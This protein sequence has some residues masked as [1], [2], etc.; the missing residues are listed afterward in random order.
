MALIRATFA[1][2]HYFT[3]F[4]NDRPVFKVL[5]AVCTL[6]AVADAAC[7]A[8]WSFFWVGEPHFSPSPL[9][10]AEVAPRTVT[11]YGDIFVLMGM[12]WHLPAYCG[13]CVARA[14]HLRRPW[15]PAVGGRDAY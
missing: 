8:D 15:S 14:L 4:K 10:C 1:A 7:N 6:L 5:V 3:T 12:P 9:R 11:N 2:H 13:M